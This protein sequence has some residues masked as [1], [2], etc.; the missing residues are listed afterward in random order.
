MP[1]K[2]GLELANLLSTRRPGH[3]GHRHVRLHRGDAC[4]CSGLKEPV[5]LLQKPFTPRELR[6]RIREV[7]DRYA[8]RS[9]ICRRRS[10]Q[11]RSRENLRYSC[12]AETLVTRTLA[13]AQRVSG[14]SAGVTP[15]GQRRARGVHHHRQHRVVAGDADDVDD[16][17]ARRSCRPP[18][19]RCRRSRPGC[20]ASRRTA[21]RRSPRP[22][23]SR[24]GRRPSAIA[25]TMSAL[26]PPLTRERRDARSTRTAASSGARSAGSR[27]RCSRGG[28]ELSEAQVVAHRPRA[29]H[30]LRAAQQRARTGRRCRPTARALNSSIAFFCAS[31]SLSAGI[32]GIRSCAPRDAA[33]PTTAHD[34]REHELEHRAPPRHSLQRRLTRDH[35]QIAV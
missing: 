32:G 34:E 10:T 19:R 27:T 33:I 5:A 24:S 14:A 3:P 6:R 31:V 11:S 17:P 20:A 9:G 28:S 22:R 7:L 29:A 35:C 1:G 25:S 18:A 26:Q 13:S 2:S 23:P 8:G 16:A 4:R 30:H 21:S 15:C 12:V